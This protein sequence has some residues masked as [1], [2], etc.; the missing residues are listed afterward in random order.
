MEQSRQ[1]LGHLVYGI[2]LLTARRG[3]EI[4]GMPLSWAT[5]V[6][7]DPP[8]MAICV[9]KE[10]YTNQMINESGVFAVHLLERS[11]KDHVSTFKARDMEKSAKFAG[12]AFHPGQT[13]VP[14]LEDCIGYIECRVVERIEPGDHTIFIGEVV[15]GGWG[16]DGSVLSEDDLGQY[17]S[18]Y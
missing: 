7:F 9:K 3:D 8:L 4:N 17:Y 12:H 1:V 13:G 15:S 10:R 11:Q 2:Y 16:R 5:Q 6:S 14:I 18:R